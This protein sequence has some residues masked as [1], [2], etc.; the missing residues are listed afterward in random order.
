[1]QAFVWNAQLVRVFCLGTVHKRRRQFFP[2][3]W[4]PPPPWLDWPRTMDAQWS[5]F[6]RNPNILGF[7]RQFGQIKFGAFGVFSADLSTP[8]LVQWVPCQYFP[9]INNYFYKELSLYIRIPNIHLELGFEIGPQRIRNL[10]I[11]CP[12][13]VRLTITE[14][15]LLLSVGK[16][17]PKFDPF[18]IADVFYERPLTPRREEIMN[19]LRNGILPIFPAVKTYVV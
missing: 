17:W 11:V 18:S 13:S 16:L 19:M 3:F 6:Y 15:Y 10:A 12:Q 8:I 4:H 1:M 7:G 2:D 9:L 14:V 5:L